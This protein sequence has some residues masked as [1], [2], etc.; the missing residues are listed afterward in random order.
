MSKVVHMTSVHRGDDTRIFGRECRT[1]G[2]AGYQVVL[3]A[4]GAQDELKEGVRLHGVPKAKSRLTRM[5]K[6]VSQ[7]YMAAIQE[8]AEIYHLH[9]PELVWPAILL[10]IKGKKS[11]F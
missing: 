7:V 10:R 1:L 9:D 2:K 4:P 6:T 11:S 8:D 3:V 5:I